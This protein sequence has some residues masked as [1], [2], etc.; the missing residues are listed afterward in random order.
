[1]SSYI[2]WEFKS[3]FK[4]NTIWFSAIAIIYLLEFVILKSGGLD[5]TIAGLITIAFNFILMIS[6]FFAFIYGTKRTIDTF[7]K[8]TFL[9]ES[10][11]PISASKL[12]LAKYLIAIV[13][14]IIYA[15][16]Y[17]LGI[18]IVMSAVENA[19][20]REM[21]GEIGEFIINNPINILR[22]FIVMIIASTAF[23]SIVTM[24]FCFFK[25]KFPNGKAVS[26]I[27]YIL[28]YFL[29]GFVISLFL[30]MIGNVD[31]TYFDI[32]MDGFMLIMATLGYLG[33]VHLVENKL[34]IYN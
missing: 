7:S 2:K 9:L 13:M 12:L 25:S 30:E 1:M 33:T 22:V 3:I 23:T 6:V 24:V 5:N 28:G 21:L 32:I 27:S 20:L 8:P 11:I 16:I 14:N 29:F 10:M 26:V 4:K 19:T 34:E 17:I 31:T 15:F 18:I